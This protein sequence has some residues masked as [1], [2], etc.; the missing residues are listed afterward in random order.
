MKL[1]KSLLAIWMILLFALFIVPTETSAQGI[2]GVKSHNYGTVANSVDEAYV[3]YT[4]VGLLKE[5]GCNKIDSLVISLTAV[6]EL[7]IDSLMWYPVSW[8]TGGT[9]VKGTVAF[10]TV[11]LN[12]AAGV[13]GKEVLYSANAGIASALWRGTEGFTL[14]TRG[15]AAGNDATDP[16]SLKV[17]I[18][19][20]GS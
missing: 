6:G 1:H 17:T 18:T 14:F 5:F 12:L 8:T 3:S 2:V 13:A 4:W 16:N 19:F 20:Y 10:R 15:A 9:A 7:D 11:T